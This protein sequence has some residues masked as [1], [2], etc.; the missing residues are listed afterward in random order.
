MHV[1]REFA[2]VAVSYIVNLRSREILSH[3]Y[4]GAV[5]AKI[6]TLNELDGMA[7]KRDPQTDRG[8]RVGPFNLVINAAEVTILR[9]IITRH[10]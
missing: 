8:W 1:Q 6:G 4:S 9:L 10:K 7:G 5:A 3:S 2:P